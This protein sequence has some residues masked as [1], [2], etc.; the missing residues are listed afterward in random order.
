MNSDLSRIP[1]G[2][3]YFFDDEVRL[4]RSIER[5]VMSVFFGWSY[6][7]V[8]LPIFDYQDLFT[9]GMGRARASK[10]YRFTDREGSQLALRPDLTSL[11]ARTVA[12]RFAE[13]PRP[14]RLC[15]TGEIFRF[16][17]PRAGRQYEFHHIGIEHIGNNRFEADVEVLLIAIE[18][19]WR[20]GIND[21]RIIIGNAEFFN[22]IVERLQLD[23]SQRE[24]MR[25][26]IDIRNISGL[27][28]MVAALTNSEHAEGLGRLMKLSGSR[29]IIEN[30]RT[31][32]SNEK[33]Q[34]ALDHLQ[35]IFEIAAAL[36]IDRYI[37]IDLGDVGGLD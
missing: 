34:T 28:E 14:L 26:L 2:V 8:L 4:R 30:A 23:E 22:G 29:E 20:L 31:L 9:R 5:E 21:F 19:L 15:Y 33:S 35:A 1:S 6:A 10:T 25:D 37:E 12:T 27:V 11:V 13:R 24:K 7:E 32:V 18:S 16:D 17:E 3:R 36:D